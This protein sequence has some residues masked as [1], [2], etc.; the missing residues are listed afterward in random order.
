MRAF[1]EAEI[2]WGPGPVAGLLELE[3]SIAWTTLQ[4]MPVRVALRELVPAGGVGR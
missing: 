1:R 3:V 4:G 2:R